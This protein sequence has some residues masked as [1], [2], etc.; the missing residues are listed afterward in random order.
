MNMVSNPVV[1]I[2]AS[3][4][5]GSARAVVVVVERASRRLDNDARESTADAGT[6]RTME[7]RAARRAGPRATAEAVVRETR[8]VHAC[9]MAMCDDAARD[10][11]EYF[12]L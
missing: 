11:C 3:S 6:R 9:A 7:A 12:F 4:A 10:D 8:V 5:T 1:S 2:P